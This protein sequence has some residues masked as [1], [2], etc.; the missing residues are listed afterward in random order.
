MIVTYEQTQCLFNKILVTVVNFSKNTV[1]KKYSVFT[2]A[3]A[4]I[5]IK[6]KGMRTALR[7]ANFYTAH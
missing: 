2:F 1:K 6:D 7:G 5:L 4:I 3:D